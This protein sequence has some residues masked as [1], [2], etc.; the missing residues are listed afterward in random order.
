[1][2]GGYGESCE[3]QIK[4]KKPPPFSC[5]NRRKERKVLGEVKN[6][7]AKVVVLGREWQKLSI[8][9]AP[10]SS[11]QAKNCIPW[12]KHMNQITG[13]YVDHF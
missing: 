12:H 9:A 2:I 13:F 4:G 8:A 11:G 10:L 3:I 7:D 6:A 5:C 1:M